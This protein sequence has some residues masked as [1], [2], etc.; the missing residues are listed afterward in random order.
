M[1]RV[2]FEGALKRESRA[3]KP[4]PEEKPRLSNKSEQL[5]RKH[6]E[7]IAAKSRQITGDGAPDTTNI[8]EVL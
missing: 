1:N 5:A 7:K 8:V 2:H 3:A 6:R 4:E